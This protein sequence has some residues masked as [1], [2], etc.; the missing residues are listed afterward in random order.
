APQNAIDGAFVLSC[1]CP[2]RRARVRGRPIRFTD[3]EERAARPVGVNV[4]VNDDGANGHRIIVK[5]DPAGAQAVAA[6]PPG[7][8]RYTPIA[9]STLLGRARQTLLDCFWARDGAGEPQDN[10]IG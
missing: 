2:N 10:V 6:P 3:S 7:W 4:I 9:T 8:A 5:T 1:T